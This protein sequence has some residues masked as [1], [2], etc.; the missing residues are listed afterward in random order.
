MQKNGRI[1]VGKTPAENCGGR[2]CD[3]IKDG[4]ALSTKSG[5]TIKQSSMEID[6]LHRA[7]GR[8]VDVGNY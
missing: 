3:V 6:N 5:K 4:K 7:A 2:K 1:E 8:V